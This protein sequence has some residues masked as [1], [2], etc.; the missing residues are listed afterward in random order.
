MRCVQFDQP[1][2]LLRLQLS[3]DLTDRIFAPLL[4]P[5]SRLKLS[6]AI[7][8]DDSRRKRCRSGADKKLPHDQS[9]AIGL[10]SDRMLTVSRFCSDAGSIR[11][12]PVIVLLLSNLDVGNTADFIEV[13]DFE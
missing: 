7:H 6:L 9:L 1:C 8:R 12:V 4:P 11:H 10:A 5:K 3:W 2:L 13:S